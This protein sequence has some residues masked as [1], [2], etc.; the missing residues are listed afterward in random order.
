MKIKFRIHPKGTL[1]N[2]CKYMDIINFV[3]NVIGIVLLIS[4]LPK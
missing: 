2:K 3:F 1:L 4:E